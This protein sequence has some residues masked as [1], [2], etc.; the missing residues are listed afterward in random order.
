MDK[1]LLLFFDDGGRMVGWTIC[2]TDRKMIGSHALD[3][4]TSDPNSCS[5]EVYASGEF[6][7]ALNG[8]LQLCTIRL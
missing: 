2:E 4:L 6:F 8:E 7:T 5:V 1:F 3:L